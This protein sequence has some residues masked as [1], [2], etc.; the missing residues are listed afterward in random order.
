MKKIW[1]AAI[2]ATLM[3]AGEHK[4]LSVEAL[5]GIQPGMGTVMMEYGHRFYIL[6][7]A[8]KADNWELAAYELHEQLEIQ[9][10]G[11]ITRPVYAGK[12]KTFEEGYLSKLAKSIETKKWPEF[13]EVYTEVT[14]ACNRCHIETGHGYIHYRLP[15]TPP[16]LLKM[17]LK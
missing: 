9:E 3:S 16:V 15:D 5:S 6:Y 4:T 17:D 2:L 11:E 14:K 12:L 7:Y 8:A 10:V 1:I 13:K